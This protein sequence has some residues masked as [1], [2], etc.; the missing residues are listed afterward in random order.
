M[1]VETR[2]CIVLTCDVCGWQGGTDC[3][4][5][6]EEHYGTVEQA[7]LDGWI[8]DGDTARCHA[9]EMERL[10]ALVGHEWSEWHTGSDGGRFRGCDN[11]HR[12]ETV[13]PEQIAVGAELAAEHMQHLPHGAIV[14]IPEVPIPYIGSPD[15]TWYVIPARVLQKTG[16]GWFCS[17]IEGPVEPHLFLDAPMRIVWLPG[18]DLLPD[19]D[20]SL[21]GPDFDQ[22]P[23]GAV[24]RT[25]FGDWGVSQ[26]SAMLKLADGH[27]AVTGQ[28]SYP[29]LPSTNGLWAELLALPGLTSTD[30]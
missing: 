18:H 11:C 1:S 2:T 24:A 20:T 16:N 5:G 23:V 14:V 22:A 3:A 19:T 15:K 21:T 25:G 26:P 7:R 8:V 27:W 28:A 6:S 30:A 9:C 4:P 10:C 17:G 29:W 12:E 13:Q